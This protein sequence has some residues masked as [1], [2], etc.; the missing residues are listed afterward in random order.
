MLNNAKKTLSRADFEKI[1]TRVQVSGKKRFINSLL[2]SSKSSG[3]NKI[4]SW[5]LG[6]V[7]EWAGVD[8]NKT[9]VVVRNVG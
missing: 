3:Q 6:T 4:F 9:Y 8:V 5:Y 2:F 7:N 1:F